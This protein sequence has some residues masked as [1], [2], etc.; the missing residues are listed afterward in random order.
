[1]NKKQL[2]AVRKLMDRTRYRKFDV[3]LGERPFHPGSEVEE[4]EE[5]GRISFS[6]SSNTPIETFIFTEDFM[7]RAFEVLSHKEGDVD[8]SR[9]DAGTGHFIL[10]HNP[11]GVDSNLGII[12]DASVDGKRLNV[13][14]KFNPH[15]ET[16]AQ[17]EKEMKSGFRS[18]ISIG[19]VR[20]DS[21]ARMVGE[22]DGIPVFE[23]NF[24][25]HEISSV[26]IPADNS[27]G[28]G[29]SDEELLMR[30]LG[31]DDNDESKELVSKLL[32]E[33]ES[34]SDVEIIEELER[35][36][37]QA[38]EKESEDITDEALLI[39]ETKS[40]G[41]STAD[42]D[43]FKEQEMSEKTQDESTVEV[44]AGPDLDVA[45]RD[46]DA[47]VELCRSQD[48]LEMAL[49]AREKGWT[50]EY[51][52][53][54]LFDAAQA[55]R[56]IEG[57]TPMEAG[58][59]EQKELNLPS[60]LR[61]FLESA[62]G[63]GGSPVNDL[64]REIAQAMGLST[65]PD[66]MYIPIHRN[67][68]QRVLQTSP[69]DQGGNLVGTDFR[70]L[71]EDLFEETLAAEVGMQ[72]VQ[73][74]S[75]Q[76]IP[77]WSANNVASWVGEDSGISEASGAL[78]IVT[79]TP[80]QLVSHVGITPFLGVA[81][82]GAYD[83]INATLDNMVGSIRDQAELSIWNGAGS[84]EP[85]GVLNDTSITAVTTASADNVVYGALWE[86]VRDAGHRGAGPF[87]VSSD[88]YRAGVDNPALASGTDRAT[89]TVSAGIA[90]TDYGR[91]VDSQHLPAQS[92]LYGSFRSVLVADFG[93]LE[94]RRD[95]S[96]QAANGR[97]VLI[98]RLFM[99]VV[100][101]Q[102]GTLA[103]IDGLIDLTP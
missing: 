98:A 60:G 65:R 90:S 56:Q 97:D 5:K 34:P 87:V 35:T 73:V 37:A 17:V 49:E 9:F 38:D 4:D 32:R 67:L 64:G 43:S 53:G 80:N 93:V 18:N 33:M 63:Q 89:I 22:K 76:Q 84:D 16:A 78:A 45:K 92:A 12:T 24:A 20:D 75:N 41:D 96:M 44:T 68:G 71:A 88:V 72:F 95:I 77:R 99:D 54:Q 48:N 1:M 61:N 46:V 31:L 30:E 100:V 55:D 85:L 39:V 79:A 94:V 19:F 50:L 74:A 62:A 7:G 86:T 36:T 52:K 6:A 40:V 42:S 51:T 70:P 10:D 14:V 103:R 8:L 47:A 29:R 13:D 26:I 15:N 58:N 23:F 81:V 2:A 91:V 69:A 66:A 59:R 3:E 83:P 82:D 57:F 28:V 102:P 101:Q 25:P 27:V 21:S 11:R